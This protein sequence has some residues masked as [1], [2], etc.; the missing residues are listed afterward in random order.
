VV[1]DPTGDYKIPAGTLMTLSNKSNVQNQYELVFQ[2]PNNANP[3]PELRTLSL[4]HVDRSNTNAEISLAELEA[5]YASW[6]KGAYLDSAYDIMKSQY[7]YVMGFGLV[8]DIPTL[9]VFIHSKYDET[10]GD[11]RAF[12]LV[13]TKMNEITGIKRVRHSRG[14]MHLLQGG[15]IHGHEN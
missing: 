12:A 4:V 13:L 2:D 5:K 6:T 1:C 9:A 15:V 8:N 7:D 10:P 14:T 3:A 11:C